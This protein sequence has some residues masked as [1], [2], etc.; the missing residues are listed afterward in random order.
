M[1]SFT[2]LA[3]M[4]IDT[5]T[6]MVPCGFTNDFEQHFE[7]HKIFYNSGNFF[8]KGKSLLIRCGQRVVPPHARI[9]GQLVAVCT[10][11]PVLSVRELSFR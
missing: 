9:H 3:D 7:P 1:Q 10:L 4:Y 11:F 8:I 5:A 6:L 2:F